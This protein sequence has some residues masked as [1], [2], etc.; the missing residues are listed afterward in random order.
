LESVT[1]ETNRLK[2]FNALKKSSQH[3]PKKLEGWRITPKIRKENKNCLKY[4]IRQKIANSKAELLRKALK[5]QNIR[6]AIKKTER[7]WR[8]SQEKRI[9]ALKKVVK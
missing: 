8:K 5:E 4:S 2:N 1:R 3:S 6:N 7:N 9:R